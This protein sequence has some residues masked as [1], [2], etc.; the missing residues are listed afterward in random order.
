VRSV[1]NSSAAQWN[2]V[3]AADGLKDGSSVGLL[4][5]GRLVGYIEVGKRVVVIG[6]IDGFSVRVRAVGFAVGAE[7][8]G[9]SVG[10]EPEGV[11]DGS[12]ESIGCVE[13]R[14]VLTLGCRDGKNVLSLGNSVGSSGLSIGANDG[15][16]DGMRSWQSVI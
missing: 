4:V 2:G 13:G 10:E 16:L 9:F 15:N 1:M 5:V 12:F 6:D 8:E 3:G 7:N 14:L 11:I